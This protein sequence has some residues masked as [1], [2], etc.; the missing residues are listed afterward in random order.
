MEIDVDFTDLPR[1]QT[2]DVTHL[3]VDQWPCRVLALMQHVSDVPISVGH[4]CHP[5]RLM[6]NRTTPTTRNA[7]PATAAPS[8]APVAGRVVGGRA[9]VVV[10]TCLGGGTT[11]TGTVVVRAT[12][13]VVVPTVGGGGGGG[14]ATVV[15]VVDVVVVASGVLGGHGCPH[16]TFTGHPRR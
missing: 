7:P 3:L 2:V 14:G 9:T 1:V 11:T 15:V 8:P 5:I 12:S 6:A 4:L 16:I 13:V 10:V